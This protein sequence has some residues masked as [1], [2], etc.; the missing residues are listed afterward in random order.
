M[1]KTGKD[2]GFLPFERFCKVH[3]LRIGDVWS[4]RSIGQV[5]LKA[6]TRTKA[7]NGPLPQVGAGA[8]SLIPDP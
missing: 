8:A 4:Q 7:A 5:W 1:P 2:E 3:F 6:A